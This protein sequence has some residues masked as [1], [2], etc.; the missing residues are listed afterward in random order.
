MMFVVGLKRS[1]VHLPHE[2]IVPAREPRLIVTRM[3]YN[4][5]LDAWSRIQV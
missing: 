3:Y 1:V 5:L 4:L 2:T